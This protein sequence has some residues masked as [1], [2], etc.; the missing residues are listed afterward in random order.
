MLQRVLKPRTHLTWVSLVWKVDIIA[1]DAVDGHDHR[2]KG[3]RLPSKP[4]TDYSC[5]L[6][7]ACTTCMHKLGARSTVLGSRVLY[8]EGHGWRIGSRA[9]HYS[10]LCVPLYLLLALYTGAG[11]DVAMTVTPFLNSRG[12]GTS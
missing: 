7:V 10:L 2:L 4:R 8:A 11:Q 12:R 3:P 6:G 1:P 9:A 5:I